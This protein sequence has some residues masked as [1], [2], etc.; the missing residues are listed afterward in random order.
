MSVVDM[1][2]DIDNYYPKFPGTP[3]RSVSLPSF[4]AISG[5]SRKRGSFFYAM[6][7][8]EPLKLSIL[9]LDGSCFDI[10]ILKRATVAEL[11]LAVEDAFSYM[12]RKGPGKISWP[13][14]W[15]H[16]CLT[17]DGRMLVT[18]T[19]HIRNYGIRDGDQLQ[20]IRHIS[21]S[22]S[23]KKKKKKRSSKRVAASEHY[24]MSLSSPNIYE[25]IRKEDNFYDVE[26]GMHHSY[27]ESLEK[28]ET[29]LATFF[30][31]HRW[32]SYSRMAAMETSLKGYSNRSAFNILGS[33]R[34]VLELCNDKHYYKKV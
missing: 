8:E 1:R 32:L 11:R 27:E 34:K 14:V 5:R 24:D 28:K 25:E 9:K 17:Y 4:A 20:F 29:R 26:N 15:S 13:H 21:N 18:E 31:F 19:D 6:L 12:P 30:H 7:P 2:I 10:Q 22:F 3:R 16:F 33:F 23:L